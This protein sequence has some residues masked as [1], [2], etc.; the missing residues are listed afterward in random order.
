MHQVERKTIVALLKISLWGQSNNEICSDWNVLSKIAKDQGV[1]SFVYEGARRAGLSIPDE[2]C[3]KWKN[4]IKASM[5]QNE[6]LL[7]AQDAVV[8]AFRQAGI[9]VAVLK[10]SSA[11]RYYPQP[12]LRA[13]GDID[14]L[15]KSTD[16][17]A[18][19]SLLLQDGYKECE[20]EHGFHIGFSKHG[21][22]LE[23]HQQVT[24]F[25]DTPGGQAAKKVADGFL[26][27]LEIGSICGYEF[28]VLNRQNQA[29]S[30]LLHMVRHMFE[31]GIGL[32]QLCDWAVFVASEETHFVSDVCPVLKQCG[33][34]EFAEIATETCV[35]YLGLNRDYCT[36]CGA[37]DK[38][39][40]A[41]FID[42]VFHGGNMG[43]ASTDTMGSLFTDEKS[44]GDNSSPITALARKL[45]GI[46]Y[47][48]FP[49]VERAKILLPLFWVYL[50]IRY[51]YRSVVGLR[52][53]K[54]IKK[55]V[56][57]AKKQRVLFDE[58]H[59]FE[60]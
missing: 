50:P 60:I 17:P 37:V 8:R 9:P 34:L 32:R 56:A 2:I 42:S 38:E 1:A 43:S 5:F 47:K 21:V 18:A 27:E 3:Q 59:L 53:K 16:V 54:S 44:M 58:L 11:A 36:W 23:L 33:L 45:N 55:T 4:H 12:E 52:P 15:V 24:A 31:G 49:F 6:R 29:L 19:R 30:L 48:S 51:F 41:L 10:G 22:Y 14:L 28:P 20:Y 13:L 26:D 7:F 57:S 46:I 39:T 25:P 40:C 35:E